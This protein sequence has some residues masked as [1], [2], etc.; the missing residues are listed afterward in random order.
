VAILTNI[1]GMERI[2]EESVIRLRVDP[3]KDENTVIVLV[4]A[5]VR[6][7]YVRVQAARE[8]TIFLGSF[9]M[10]LCGATFD[11]NE[12]PPLEGCEGGLLRTG[13][14]TPEG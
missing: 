7:S 10:P 8:K 14:P 9:F 4:V 6:S 11:E 1:A 2:A 13:R 12:S 3:W 5:V